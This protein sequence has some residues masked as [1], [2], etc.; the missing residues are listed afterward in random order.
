[1]P[2]LDQTG[3]GSCR[4]KHD[5]CIHSMMGFNQNIY[6]STSLPLLGS[7]TAMH[8]DVKTIWAGQLV[9]ANSKMALFHL[10]P[11]TDTLLSSTHTFPHVV[12][13]LQ[14]Y[15]CS[16]LFAI[17]AYYF[18]K[19]LCV[20]LSG[21]FDSLAL[22]NEWM[23]KCINLWQI[24]NFGMPCFYIVFLCASWGEKTSVTTTVSP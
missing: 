21:H 20:L 11:H 7:D 18:R 24:S 12:L 9:I 4:S 8:Q 5:V 2:F 13:L 23:I 22:N 16:C 1:M 17:N 6:R 15:T 19:Q 10:T 3:N 14:L